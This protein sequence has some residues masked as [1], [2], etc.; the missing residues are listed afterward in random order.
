MKVAIA[1]DHNLVRQGIAD[2]LKFQGIEVD[3]QACNGQEMVDYATEHHPDIVLMDL[4]MPVMD[5]WQATKELKKCS[6]NTRVIALSVLDDD[7]SVIRMLRNGARGYLLKDSEPQDLV[8]AIKSVFE[9]GFYHSDFVSSRLMK[10]MTDSADLDKLQT[11]DSI[12]D[13]ELEFLQLACT[14]NTYNEISD[15]M[16]LSPRTIDGYRDTL[17]KKLGIK[18]RVG[19]VIYAI[20]NHLVEV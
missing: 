15:K 16:F 3:F 12:K 13:R 8:D 9:T 10:A 20:K 17:F 2:M 14:E 6:P 5:G 7:L 1:D 19:L 4:N 11:V 18:S